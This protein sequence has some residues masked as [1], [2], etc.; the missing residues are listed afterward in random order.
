MITIA[1]IGSIVVSSS[2]LV[3]AAQRKGQSFG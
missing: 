2:G 3:G 1:T